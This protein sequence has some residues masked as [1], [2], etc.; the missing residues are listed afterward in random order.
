MRKRVIQRINVFVSTENLVSSA[1]TK[2]VLSNAE[3]VLSNAKNLL[4]SAKKLLSSAENVKLVPIVY[5]AYS[6]CVITSVVFCSFVKFFLQNISFPVLIALYQLFRAYYGY[7][8][9]IF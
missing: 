1:E 3:N 8:K 4:S 9:T 6:E 5:Y 7:F 2:N